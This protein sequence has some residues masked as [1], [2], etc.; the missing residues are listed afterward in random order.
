MALQVPPSIWKVRL[1][2]HESLDFYACRSIALDYTRL[3][4]HYNHQVFHSEKC[5]TR[6]LH[7]EGSDLV[8]NAQYSSLKFSGEQINFFTLF[9]AQFIAS[10]RKY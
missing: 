1:V 2:C 7:A 5:H 3:I 10:L 4:F 9:L 8:G 6:G